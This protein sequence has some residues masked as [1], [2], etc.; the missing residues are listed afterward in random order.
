MI[1]FDDFD[2]RLAV[3][4]GATQGIGKATCQMLLEAGATVFGLA[5]S[6]ADI[7]HA[8]FVPIACDLADAAAI[9]AALATVRGQTARL[10][11]VVNVAGWDPKWSIEEGTAEKWDYLVDL[12]LRAY[13]LII[14]A[15]VPLL[16]LGA[17]KAIVNVSSINYRLGV[18]KRSVYSATKAGNLGLTWGLARELGARGI[19]VNAVTPGW[20]FTERQTQEYFDDPV[21]GPDYLK[22]LHERQSLTHHITAQDIA[23]HILFYLSDASRASTGHN[24]VV[25]AGWLLE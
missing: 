7:A 17:G 15:A 10:D 24:C 14:R 21:K 25:D 16:E 1:T 13:Y 6:A 2:G 23:T 12:N 8:R 11:Y 4:T 20:V 9:A 18:P 5:R 3:V 22:F 19:R